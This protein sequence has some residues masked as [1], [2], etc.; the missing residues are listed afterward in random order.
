MYPQR[1]VA[2]VHLYPRRLDPRH[3]LVADV[4]VTALWMGRPGCDVSP[5]CERRSKDPRYC[6]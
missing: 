3:D 1:D 6:P 4:A 5:Y 2:V